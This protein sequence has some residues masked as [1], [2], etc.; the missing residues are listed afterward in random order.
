ME[1]NEC[2]CFVKL[3]IDVK[4]MK[5]P[6]QIPVASVC[7]CRPSFLRG[8]IV[9]IVAHGMNLTQLSQCFEQDQRFLG[10]FCREKRVSHE[11]V[12][13]GLLSYCNHFDHLNS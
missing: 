6:D 1:L 2:V 9:S 13:Y 5:N 7:L 10:I 4:R 3:S 8:T 12:S 11:S